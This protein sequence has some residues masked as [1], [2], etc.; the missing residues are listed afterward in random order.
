MDFRRSELEH[1]LGKR[2]RRTSVPN[3]EEAQ[4][5][6]LTAFVSAV[7]ALAV[8]SSSA[9]WGE[10]SGAQRFT[11]VQVGEEQARVFAAG[12]V[13]GVGVDVI[14]SE[15]E[16]PDGSIQFTDAFVFNGGTVRISGTG[17]ASGEF[18]PKTCVGRRRLAGSFVLLG[19]EGRFSGASGS[20]NWTGEVTFGL[21]RT[22]SGC[23]EQETFSMVVFR[24]SGTA[25]LAAAA[26]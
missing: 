3:R 18:D 16:N 23:S 15:A 26:K 4:L 6:R 1:E 7:L 20:G 14:E 22:R 12:P 17:T 5:K 9:A 19:G 8:T 13:T 21:R 2:Q 24:F 10:T 11:V 25:M